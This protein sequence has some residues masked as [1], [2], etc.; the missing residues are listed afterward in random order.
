MIENKTECRIVL[1]S[2]PYG[3]RDSIDI[4]ITDEESTW[5]Q[6]RWDDEAIADTTEELEVVQKRHLQTINRGAYQGGFKGNR[7][8]PSKGSVRTKNRKANKLAK[9]A[10]KNK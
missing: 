4:R 5:D 1:V 8:R 6:E 10:R 7:D 2:T 3:F 9:K